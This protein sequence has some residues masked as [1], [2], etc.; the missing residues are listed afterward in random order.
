MGDGPMAR[1]FPE[2]LEAAEKEGE[3]PTPGEVEIFRFLRD[4]LKPDSEF[5]AYYEAPVGRG[6]ARKWPDF[7]LFGRYLGLVVI[8]VKDWR[9]EDIVRFDKSDVL[10]DVG[11]GFEHRKNPE[12][13]AKTYGDEVVNALKRQ[14]AVSRQQWQSW[15]R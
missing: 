8:E 3:G 5:E 2:S 14:R 11:S 12:R 6:G 4:A 10:L 1:M 9:A 13:Q 15:Y 7:V